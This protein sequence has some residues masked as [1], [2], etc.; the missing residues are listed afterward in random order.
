MI[1]KKLLGDVLTDMGVVGPAQLEEALQRQRELLQVLE[2]SEK[3][4][5]PNLV[6]EVRIASGRQARPMLGQILTELRF[7]TPEQLA[8][9]LRRQERMAELYTNLDSSKLGVIIEISS[10]INSTLN[11]AEVLFLIMRHANR[12]TAS[13]AS[14]LMLLD[15][16]SDELVF[17]VPT[18]PKADKLMDIRI[19]S[20]K[21]IAGWVARHSRSLRVPDVTKDPRFYSGIDKESGFR[22]RSVLCVPIK[23]KAKLIGVLEV[24]NKQDD[25]EFNEEDE[26]LLSIFA[27]QAALAIENARLHQELASRMGELVSRSVELKRIQNELRHSLQEK[28]VLLRE[29]HHRVKNNMQVIQSLLR[30]QA[31]KSGDPRLK[32]LFQEGQSRIHAMSLIHEILYHSENLARIDL[33]E[34][35]GQLTRQLLQIYGEKGRR[36]SIQVSG[37]ISLRIDQAIPF[38]LILNELFSNALKH[39]FPRGRGGGISLEVDRSGESSCTLTVKDDGVGLPEGL[40]AKNSRT[41]GLQLVQGLVEHQ[42]GGSLDMASEKG[43]T[44]TIHFPMDMSDHT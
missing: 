21:G 22:T 8:E 27:G 40:D 4:R 15:E 13:V 30:L 11:L 7:A 20:G 39:A 16:A 44:F 41:L 12:V 23:T 38:G 36:V 37:E 28:E 42:L 35:I 31:G 1:F 32:K 19:P 25:S 14:T 34:Y 10:L 43:S 18:G 26:L 33:R 2:P 17:S 9:A 3:T 6:S 29:I 24:L 5:R